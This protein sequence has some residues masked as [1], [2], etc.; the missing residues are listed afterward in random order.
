MGCDSHEWSDE[1]VR[2]FNKMS[3]QKAPKDPPQEISKKHPGE[4]HPLPPVDK[5]VT[6]TTKKPLTDT[7]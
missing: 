3:E 2:Y 1:S 5:A 4:P 6:E 7:P